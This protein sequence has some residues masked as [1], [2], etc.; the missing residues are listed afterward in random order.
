M[1]ALHIAGKYAS[2]NVASLLIDRLAVGILTTL[3]H[4][5]MLALHHMCKCKKEKSS[6][7]KKLLKRLKLFLNQSSL[8]AVL[9]KKDRYENTIFDLAIKENHLKIIEILLKVNPH[10]SVLSDHELNL[11]IHIAAKFSGTIRTLELLEKYECVSFEGNVNWNNVFHL[12][13]YSN[14]LDFI[15]NLMAKYEHRVEMKEALN[16]FNADRHTPLLCAIAKGSL[17]CAQFLI[18]KQVR[19]NKREI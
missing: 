18:N 4:N 16:A 9:S 5:R 19:A 8:I 1:T 14:K 7:V 6:V 10:Y 17:E 3:D 12:A 11:P 15:E 13:A 2:E